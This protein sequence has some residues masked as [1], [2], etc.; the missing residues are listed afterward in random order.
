M[1]KKAHRQMAA[2]A[3]VALA[4][5]AALIPVYTTSQIAG[6]TYSCGAAIAAAFHRWPGCREAAPPYLIGAVILLAATAMVVIGMREE[7]EGASQ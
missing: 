5:I 4:A 7:E 1:A 2:V 3:G 6:E